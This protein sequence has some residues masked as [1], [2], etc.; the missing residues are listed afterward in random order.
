[1][2]WK[3]FVRSLAGNI[4]PSDPRLGGLRTGFLGL[5]ICMGGLLVFL[6]GLELVGKIVMYAGIMIGFVGMV[7]HF[8]A[9]FRGKGSE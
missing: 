5:L 1:M 8:V 9:L 3:T 6:I 2:R 4:E 7:I